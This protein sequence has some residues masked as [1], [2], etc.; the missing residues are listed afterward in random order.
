MIDKLISFG[1]IDFEVNC[2]EREM[3]MLHSLSRCMHE[4]HSTVQCLTVMC[5]WLDSQ[6]E[7]QY[8]QLSMVDCMV[9]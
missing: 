4:S 7:K 8:Q 9:E 6:I 5:T 1:K 2:G 3:G